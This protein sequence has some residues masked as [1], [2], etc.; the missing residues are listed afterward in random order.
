MGTIAKKL[1]LRTDHSSLAS[2]KYL[3]EP[4]DPHFIPDS[5]LIERQMLSE[6]EE[7]ELKRVCALLLANVPHS[8]DM[9]DDPFRYMAAHIQD[10]KAGQQ[11]KREL[12]SQPV[13][14]TNSAP[15][16]VS[17]KPVDTKLDST[18][19]SDIS[20]LHTLNATDNSTPLTSAGL[21][22]GDSRAALS[23]ATRRSV[24][25][26][27]KSASGLRTEAAARTDR[28][29]KTSSAGR[30]KSLESD[31][32]SPD[33]DEVKGTVRLVDDRSPNRGRTSNKSME[34]NRTAARLSAPDLNK[35][36]PPPPPSPPLRPAE[37]PHPEDPKQPHI[38]RLMKTIRKKS[39]VPAE[40][41][42][43]SAT[44]GT[45]TS[46]APIPPIPS[47]EDRKAATA[48]TLQSSIS[49]ST[50]T[51]P[52]PEIIASASA[53]Q[54]APDHP[55]KRFR[56]RLFHRLHRPTGVLVT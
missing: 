50:Q 16:T 19:P 32:H 25:S 53:S 26:A 4:D 41:R 31:E 46:T 38:S 49:P 35:S 30:Q 54:V 13:Q 5:P 45:G 42:K 22:P 39:Q 40:E 43:A 56:L 34:N 51:G 29:R 52:E 28:S 24:A 11:R 17:H 8:D 7:G 20:R 44:S 18:T 27:R 3:G 15:T 33:L 14:N 23:D 48:A 2:K 36:L 6:Q 12:P 37:S 21:T 55:K 47:A 1:R 9:S 10:G